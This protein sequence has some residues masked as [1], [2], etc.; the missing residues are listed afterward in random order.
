M[1][2]SKISVAKFLEQQIAMSDKT[3]R[4]IALECGYEKPNIMTMFKSGQ[5]KV[6]L[7][8]VALLAKAL[9]ID[10]AYMLKLVLTEY[11]PE[12]WEAIEGIV[13]EAKLVSQPE[14]ELVKFIRAQSGNVIPDISIKENRDL[15]GDAVK[16]AAKRDSDKAAAAV[17]GY[18]SRPR[19]AKIAA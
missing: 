18:N 3:Q 19:N 9:N 6:P 17:T 7:N 1:V 2:K 8:K 10:P 12:T 5:T 11:S 13:G 4:E 16:Q 14:L 15:I